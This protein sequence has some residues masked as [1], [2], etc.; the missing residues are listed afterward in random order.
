MS[1]R[2]FASLLVASCLSCTAAI[3]Q[4]Q[5]PVK[6]GLLATFSGPFGI[7]GQAVSNAIM[8]EIEANGGKLGGVPVEVIKQD[9]QAKPDVGL[10][11][12]TKLVEQDKVDILIGPTLTNVILA[13]YQPVVQAKVVM[14]STVGG[15]SELAGKFCNPYFFSTSW[16]NSD[17]AASMGQHLQNKGVKSLYIQAPNFEGGR[18]VVAGLKRYYKGSVVK[19]VFTPMTQQDFSA[20]L[21]QI[22]LAAPEAV[23]AFYPGS[24]AINFVKQYAQAG[25]MSKIPLYTASSIDGTN[26]PGMGD[27]PIGSYQTASWNPDL[28]NEANQKFVVDYRKKYN[29]V[30]PFYAAYAYDAAR[31]LAS[32]LR[33][34][35]GAGDHAALASA[36]EKADFES[37]RGNFKFSR[38]HFPM[39]DYHLLEVVKTAAGVVEQQTRGKVFDLHGDDFVEQCSMKR[40]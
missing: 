29:A 13:A 40:N 19:E 5:K 20:E 22:R 27:A 3:A 15:P 14:I 26:L 39:Q 7:I 36:M 12:A 17:T 38:N 24:L 1:R 9:D 2:L 11:A 30:P 28:P 31:L 34:T 10:Q 4:P 16:Q 32:A 37:V 23:F 21:T 8:M 35:G 6:I 25:L 18:E 33:Q